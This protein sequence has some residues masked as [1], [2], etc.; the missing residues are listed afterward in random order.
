MM[1]PQK[2][3]E[4]VDIQLLTSSLSTEAQ[5]LLAPMNNTDE[6][7]CCFEDGLKSGGIKKH[8]NGLVRS[9]T[10]TKDTKGN[11]QDVIGVHDGAVKKGKASGFSRK[12]NGAIR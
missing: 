12:I 5:N 6:L 7:K 8:F 9:V 1:N 2:R 11:N 3:N 4:Y 10:Y